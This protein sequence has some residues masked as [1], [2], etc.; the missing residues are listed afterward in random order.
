VTRRAPTGE[1][2]AAAGHLFVF[3]GAEPNTDWLAGAGAALD[4][5]SGG[6][7]GRLKAGLAPLRRKGADRPK[8]K[9]PAE[10]GLFPSLAL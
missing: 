10:A 1:A 6:G 3:I 9:S 4:E 2:T 8:K 7:P 5:L